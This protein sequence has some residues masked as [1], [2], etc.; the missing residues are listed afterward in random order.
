[1][2]SPLPQANRESE[3]FFIHSNTRTR[4]PKLVRAHHATRPRKEGSP[5]SHLQPES[6]NTRVTAVVAA[7]RTPLPACCVSRSV[8]AFID[9][10]TTAA[11]KL[12]G[13]RTFLTT[14]TINRHHCQSESPLYTSHILLLFSSVI[15]FGGC[16]Q[17]WQFPDPVRN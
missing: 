3:H 2:A 16:L 4:V 12:V 5:T 8:M 9:T 10:P 1:M 17:V 13:A 15:Y 7:Q 14:S 11:H 6:S